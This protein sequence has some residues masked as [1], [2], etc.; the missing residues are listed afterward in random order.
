MG[1]LSIT[2]SAESG[3]ANSALKPAHLEVVYCGW[4]E[5]SFLFYCMYIFLSF[6]HAMCSV[7]YF[8]LPPAK[9]KKMCAVHNVDISKTC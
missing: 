5:V 8:Q 3:H 7:T 4:R 1:I 2:A 9:E 6:G